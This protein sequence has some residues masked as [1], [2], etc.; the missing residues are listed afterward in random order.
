[1][2]VY[3]K[4]TLP[5]ACSYSVGAHALKMINLKKVQRLKAYHNLL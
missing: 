3:I 4:P 5:K 1:M 2:L